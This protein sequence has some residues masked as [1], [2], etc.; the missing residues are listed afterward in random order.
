VTP[1]ACPT[2][3]TNCAAQLIATV[4]SVSDAAAI[5]ILKAVSTVSVTPSTASVFEGDQSAFS[6]VARAADGTV[7]DDRTANW[8]FNGNG[9]ASISTSGAFQLSAT[10]QSGNCPT[11][12]GS[13][14]ATIV[15]TIGGVQGTAALTVRKQVASV[16][17]S[18]ANATINQNGS[19]TLTATPRAADNTALTDRAVTWSSSANGVASVSGSGAFGQTGNVSGGTCPTGQ[20]SCSATI[21]ATAGNV[22]GTA[23]VT[24]LKPIAN[25]A[26]A[27]SASTLDEGD[28]VTLTATAT[29]ADGTVIN[30]RPLSW[31]SSASGVASV[32]GNGAVQLTADVTAGACPVGSGTCT[33]T[34]TASQGTASGQAT[35]TVVKPA[36]AVAVTLGADTVFEGG[37]TT[38]QA[39]VTA[40]DGTVLTDRQVNWSSNNGFATP[41]PTGPFGQRANISTSACPTGQEDCLATL[42]ATVANGGPQGGAGLTILKPVTNV[43]ISPTSATLSLALQPN[44]K[45]ATFTV[46][47]FAADGTQIVNRTI[48]W[49]LLNNGGNCS[50]SVNTVTLNT[51]S[52]PSVVA[53]ANALGVATLRVFVT[54]PGGTVSAVATITV[55]P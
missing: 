51:T 38:A 8:S 21:T 3:Q 15:A 37:A 29:A 2:G 7:I 41:S 49:C 30:N 48:N 24:V 36:T 32:S 28:Q 44:L 45:T 40:A 6:A 46:A 4:G 18:P 27:P 1:A 55:L 39:I 25:I 14:T 11:G 42:T 26:V 17:V 50:S 12:Q 9:V 13:C 47:A 22:S 34:I 31:S 43:V 10:V 54:Q 20:A 16:D 33:A 53:T 35:I 52:G 23:N 5:T 19:T